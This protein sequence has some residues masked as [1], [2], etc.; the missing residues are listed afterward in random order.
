MKKSWQEITIEDY[1]EI[2]NIDGESEI[3][4]K[5][6][7]ISIL[8][9]LDP[10]GVKK[11]PIKDFIRWCEEVQFVFTTAPDAN[12]NKTF[13]LNGIRYGIIPDLDLL[14]TGGEWLDSESWR[15][16]PIE[17]MH[18]YAA[19]LFRPVVKYNS[20]LDYTIEDHETKGFSQ[21]AELFRTQ[22]SVDRIYGA[23]TFFL[24]FALEYSQ[25]L[26]ASLKETETT[27][28]TKRTSKKKTP[29]QTTKKS[30]GKRSTKP[31]R[32]TIS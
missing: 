29:Q 4:R 11:A 17:N 23:Q 32:G 25:I 10:D 31:T 12:F 18:N 27:P 21:R 13:E 9:G 26:A 24:L 16:K 20:D 6:E 19:L 5:A 30:K 3:L 2:I 7:A 28:K 1:Q 15:L 8:T 14:T 22:L